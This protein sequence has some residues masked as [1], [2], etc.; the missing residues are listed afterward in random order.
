MRRSVVG[1]VA[2]GALALG[3]CSLLSPNSTPSPGPA[4]APPTASSA[5]T[6]PPS[7]STAPTTA[8]STAPT[9]GSTPGAADQLGQPVATRKSSDGGHDLVLTLYPLV[10]SGAVSTVNFT[11]TSD[12]PEED[13]FSIGDLLTDGNYQAGDRTPWTADGLQAIDGK[14]S[15]VYLVASDGHGS[16]LCSRSLL[17]V[18]LQENKPAVLSATFA[19]PPADVTTVDLRIP[20]FGTVARVPVV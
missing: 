2:V 10:R 4:S 8:P 9:A 15:K 19:A 12:V 20:N 5:P 6:D 7:G 11:L 3:G 18:D 1:L 13:K 17:N 14:N 16:C